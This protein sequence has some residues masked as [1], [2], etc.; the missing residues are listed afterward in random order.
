MPVRQMS[1][2]VFIQK[3]TIVLLRVEDFIG[4]VH[5]QGF[6]FLIRQ[7]VQSFEGNALDPDAQGGIPILFPGVYKFSNTPLAERQGSGKDKRSTFSPFDHAES[8][9]I[10][11]Q[12][13]FA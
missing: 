1:E 12:L 7:I 2:G 5:P 4:V 9:G 11:F 10:H 8:A 3:T 13:R 6:D